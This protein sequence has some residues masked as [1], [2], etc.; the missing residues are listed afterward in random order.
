MLNKKK[1]LWRLPKSMV[2]HISTDSSA[3]T[4]TT[5]PATSDLAN[6]SRMTN[7]EMEMNG[8]GAAA[9]AINNS[10]SGICVLDDQAHHLIHDQASIVFGS[11]TIDQ[12]SATPYSDATKVRESPVSRF[13]SLNFPPS[14]SSRGGERSLIYSTPGIVARVLRFVFLRFISCE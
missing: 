5:A 10:D 13:P 4:T 14:D 3:T 9:V 1:S 6:R 2:P 8:G 11:Q 12:N 7:S